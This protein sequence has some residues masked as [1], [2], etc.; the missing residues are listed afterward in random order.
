[1]SS[2]AADAPARAVRDIR[3]VLLVNVLTIPL[4]LATNLILGRISAEALGWYGAVQIFV[5]A[6]NTFVILGGAPVFSRMVPAMPS[7]ERP[8]F[9]LSYFT[10]VLGIL[11]LVTLVALVVPGAREAVLSRFGGPSWALAYGVC[12][13]ALV[14]AFATHFLYAVGKGP[15]AATALKLV[16]VGYFIAALLA[17]TVLR[18]AL[19][20][21][22][23]G[24]MWR[25]TALVYLGAA[26]VSVLWLKETAEFSGTVRARFAL[27]AGFWPVVGYTHVGTIVEFTF[28]QLYPALVLVWV[29]VLALS[30]LHAALRFVSL[31]ALVP[32]MLTS[33]LAPGLAKL[34]ASGLREQALRQAAAALRGCIVF[35]APCVYALILF[36]PAAMGIFG[37]DFGDYAR[38]L[39]FVAPMALAGPVVY[40][41][42]GMAVAF[43]AF[44]GYLWVSM[45]FVAASTVLACLVIPRWGLLGA[46]AAG[47]VGAYVQQAAMAQVIRRKLG[48]RVPFRASA[49]WIVALLTLAYAELVRPGPVAAAAGWVAALLLFALLGSVPVAEV[50]SLAARALGAS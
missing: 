22:P 38:V 48:F 36:A 26:L 18:D 10:L 4:S 8:S 25:A 30:R 7:D 33:V 5:A 47:T 1:M 20:H 9:L 35:L 2:A 32:V 34:E 27:P 24:Y 16:I 28:G 49:A 21:D 43:G 45:V 19:T 50:R 11:S 12:A 41:G 46:A 14:N 3:L 15:R 6:F 37:H 23:A 40:I 17:A 31:L 39:R 42:G 29:D 44:R 13:M